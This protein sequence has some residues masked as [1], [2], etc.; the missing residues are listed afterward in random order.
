VKIALVSNG[1]LPPAGGIELQLRGL[2]LALQRAGHTVRVITAARGPALVDGI[3]V[4][5]LPVVQGWFFRASLDPRTPRLLREVLLRERF[6]LL[7]C[8]M[9]LVAPLPLAGLA[10]A[11]SLGLPA[12]AT[13]HSVPTLESWFL[14]MFEPW[15]AWRGQRTLLTAVSP[16]VAQ[17]IGRHLGV[18]DVRWL[19]NGVHVQAWQ[20]PVEAPPLDPA[21]FHVVSFLRLVPRKRP[22]ALVETLARVR[23]RLP[24]GV[25]LRATI[26][27][28]GFLRPLV[29]RVVRFH[30]LSDCVRLTGWIAEPE[31]RRV[32]A[33]AHVFLM[34]SVREAFGISLAEA[35]SAGVPV[36]VRNA[37]GPPCFVQH[38]REGLLADSDAQLADHVV[39]LAREPALRLRIATN[40]RN[41]PLPFDWERVLALHLA[42]YQEALARR[43]GKTATVHLVGRQ[44]AMP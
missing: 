32:L 5:R 37:W 35:C 25:R 14:P 34:A 1:F 26:A 13:F 8:A 3:A 43:S 19:P 9:T 30:G 6:D 42:L 10:A 28:E 11:E 29:E 21:E 17:A 41:H 7:H 4:D 27:G 22:L 15:V 36:V 16:A 40:N 33:T 2:A 20:Q 39:R 38:G 24:A 23:D 18:P 12:V 44:Q 31:L